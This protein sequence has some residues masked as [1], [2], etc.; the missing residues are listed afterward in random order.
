MPRACSAPG[1]DTSGDFPER[2]QSCADS[3][4]PSIG[5][6]HASQFY[7]DSS[8]VHHAAGVLQ[9]AVTVLVMLLRLCALMLQSQTTNP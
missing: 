7:L 3:H 8:F 1:L 6:G 4:V 9:V 5:H 2:W